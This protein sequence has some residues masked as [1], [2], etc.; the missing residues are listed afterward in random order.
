MSPPDQLVIYDQGEVDE[1][2]E[3][4][5]II[6]RMNGQELFEFPKDARLIVG[7]FGGWKLIPIDQINEH[8]VFLPNRPVFL[9]GN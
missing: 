2:K 6:H 3:G 5:L 7:E 4:E 9:E 1:I 8:D